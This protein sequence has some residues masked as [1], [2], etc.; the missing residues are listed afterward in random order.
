MTNIRQ[1]IYR[2]VRIPC[3]FSL[4]ST[5]LFLRKHS[6]LLKIV[7]IT[8]PD[9]FN[10]HCDIA[11]SLSLS[12]LLLFVMAR[13]RTYISRYSTMDQHN[14]ER[15][16]G[17]KG[18]LKMAQNAVLF[19][20]NNLLYLHAIKWRRRGMMMGTN[21]STKF[22]FVF[23][24]YLLLALYIRS[25]VRSFFN[26]FASCFH[27]RL[28]IGACV[29]LCYIQSDNFSF[30]AFDF[31]RRASVAVCVCLYLCVCV[32]MF[33]VHRDHR[34][35]SL[36][37]GCNYPV[38]LHLHMCLWVCIFL[39]RNRFCCISQNVNTRYIILVFPIQ[40]V[41]VQFSYFELVILSLRF[42]FSV[43][44]SLFIF[45][46]CVFSFS[47]SRSSI[48]L[49]FV[50][51][52]LFLFLQYLLK[53]NASDIHDTE[54]RTRWTLSHILFLVATQF[55]ILCLGWCCS[56][57]FFSFSFF[58]I[59]IILLFIFHP[60]FLL[61][62]LCLILFI[63]ICFVFVTHIFSNIFMHIGRCIGFSCE[64]FIPTQK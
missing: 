1:C 17:E 46:F 42:L 36:S 23:L 18:F 13:M 25:L 30:G 39:I 61:L 37:F 56:F 4:F 48:P 29:L 64:L 24:P 45:T 41:R 6:I 32:W 12:V 15:R 34:V 38:C 16:V 3:R 11:L 26:P 28:W 31:C 7:G 10:L 19:L 49:Y 55:D 35:K 50:Y 40:V 27:N 47:F 52:L 53:R 14:E 44:F 8:L 21:E 58:I 62:L 5:S 33:D 43:S 57:F 63:I 20:T 51:V 60:D 54:Y 9:P 59:I 22:L 2:Y